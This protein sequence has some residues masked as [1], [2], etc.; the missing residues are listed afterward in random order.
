MKV[1]LT[2]RHIFKDLWNNILPLTMDDTHLGGNATKQWGSGYSVQLLQSQ[3][4][5]KPVVVLLKQS[6]MPLKVTAA[7]LSVLVHGI[8]NSL[9]HFLK[10]QVT[11]TSVDP[12][13]LIPPLWKSAQRQH[14]RLIL[15]MLIGIPKVD[16]SIVNPLDHVVFAVSTSVFVLAHYVWWWIHTEDAVS[17]VALLPW[18]SQSWPGWIPSELCCVVSVT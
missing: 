16:S 5:L 6:M 8:S 15:R 7:A 14:D 9:C 18:C 1:W 13:A 17:W 2:V 11:F 10:S 4:N 12:S 3:K